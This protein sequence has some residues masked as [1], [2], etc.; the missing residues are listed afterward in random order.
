MLQRQSHHSAEG[1]APRPT[2]VGDVVAV[3]PS[4]RR[5]EARRREVERPRPG[6]M[7]QA[8]E[9]GLCAKEERCVGAPL[10]DPTPSSWLA[11]SCSSMAPWTTSSPKRRGI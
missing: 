4:V 9:E 6:E 8:P 10:L 11:S 1:G 5:S 7:E 2:M 3:A